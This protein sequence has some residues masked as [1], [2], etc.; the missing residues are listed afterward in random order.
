MYKHTVT[1][2][3]HTDRKLSPFDLASVRAAASHALSPWSAVTAMDVD[4]TSSRIEDPNARI[5]YQRLQHYHAAIKAYGA[6]STQARYDTRYA[7]GVDVPSAS[8]MTNAQFR[9]VMAYIGA[10]VD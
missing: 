6:T 7:A 9:R 4:V 5:D 8:A 3:F 1:V 10:E 2:Q